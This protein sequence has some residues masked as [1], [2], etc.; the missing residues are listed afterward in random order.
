MAPRARLVVYGVRSDN[1][2]ILVDA[3]DLDVDPIMTNDVSVTLDKSEVQPGDK[4]NV[5]VKADKNSYIGLL[6][7]DQSVL[8]LKTGNDIT[9]KIFYFSHLKSFQ[10]RMSSQKSNSTTPSEAAV[11]ACAAVRSSAA[12]PC[13]DRI[14]RIGSAAT[15]R[16]VFSGTRAS[17]C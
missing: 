15:M 16:R 1:N 4:M 5:N 7:V 14:G 2:E 3:I 8:L 6:A 10:H 12:R 17:P 9:R 13:G 11:A